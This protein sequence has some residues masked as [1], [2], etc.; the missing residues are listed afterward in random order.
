MAI[1]EG[2]YI[3]SSSCFLSLGFFSFFLFLFL[4]K[5]EILLG[6]LL[7]CSQI[8]TCVDC[9]CTCNSACCFR[10]RE[11][12]TSAFYSARLSLSLSLHP[13]RLHVGLSRDK[14]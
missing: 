9:R 10:L 8:L 4:V 5:R 13:F 11:A 14:L 2:G 12:L 7:F 6:V 3:Y 1:E